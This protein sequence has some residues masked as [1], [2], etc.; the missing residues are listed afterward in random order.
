MTAFS[1]ER[2]RRFAGPL[3]GAVIA[4]G[5]LGAVVSIAGPSKVWQLVRATDG[6]RLLLALVVSAGFLSARGLR[7]WLLVDRES[8][9]WIRATL[10]AAVG[11]GAALFAPLRTGELVLPWLLAR[12]TGRDLASGF[13]ILLAA[14]TL[15]LASLGIW[16]G[17]AVL[18]VWGLSEWLAL[19]FSIALLA[20][21]ILLPWTL[22]V[23]ERLAVGFLAPRGMVGR[24][25]TRRI[26]R[27]RRELQRLVH[28]PVRLVAAAVTSV[29]M[30]G[31]QWGVAWT[32]LVAMGHLWPPIEVAA[33]ASIAAVA[34]LLPFNLIGNLG[35]L[36]AGWTAAFNALGVPLQVAAATGL[37]A[38]L[39]G[40]A[41][42][43]FFAAIAWGVLSLSLKKGTS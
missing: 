29:V 16:C 32:L 42:A 21:S 17:F 5:L 22:A 18:V 28:R 3:I 31:L 8:F 11:Q 38:H 27:V 13:G 15:D 25:W 26:R 1:S 19:V 43:A 20:P 33:G 4:L 39:W 9:G 7:L 41:F 40:L 6:P 10:V 2:S 34:N 37:A 36:E 14:R 35:T 24:R 12:T 30:W 23:A